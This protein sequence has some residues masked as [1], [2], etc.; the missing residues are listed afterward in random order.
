MFFAKYLSFALLAVGIFTA[1]LA[2]ANLLSRDRNRLRAKQIAEENYNLELAGE[3]GG[4]IQPLA[5]TLK[6]FLFL[7]GANP[8][9]QHDTVKLLAKAGYHSKSSLVYFLFFQ[10]II[11]PV[12]VVIGF[13]ILLKLVIFNQSE[14]SKHLALFLS[15]LLLAVLGI[16]GGKLFISNSVA[17]RT[18]ELKR[19]FPD[20]LDLMLICVESG[21]GIS[22]AFARVCKEMKD[23]HPVVAAE[24]DRTR[25]EMTMMND[26]IQALQN[27]GDRTGIPAVHTLVASLIQAEKF[28]TSLVDTLRMI[29]DEQRAERMLLAEEKAARLPALIT[30]PLI[31][32]ILPAL[33]MVILGPVVIKVQAQGGIFGNG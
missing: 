8:D 21:L 27:L 15:G 33:F 24:M 19:T 32:F 18:K 13:A 7:V 11:Q 10:R 4:K 16:Y 3:Y 25:F 23:S 31:F 14:I 5:L 22:A 6:P 2:L 17:K 28:G 9:K 29:A 20:A 12:L 26:R 30:I 1:Y